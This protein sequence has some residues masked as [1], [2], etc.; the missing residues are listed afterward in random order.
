MRDGQRLKIFLSF[1]F[2]ILV[3]VSAVVYIY[4]RGKRNA[5][6]D[7]SEDVMGEEI[8][9]GVPYIVTLPPLATYEGDV[10]EYSIRVVDSDTKQ[11]DLTLEYLEGPSWLELKDTVLSGTVPLGSSGTYKIILRVSDGYNTSSQENYILIEERDD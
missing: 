8:V 11:E 1:I 5:E 3:S 7:Y 6:K 4:S 9:S 10:Y 2:V